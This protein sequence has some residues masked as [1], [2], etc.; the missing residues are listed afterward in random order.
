MKAAIL[1]AFAIVTAASAANAQALPPRAPHIVVLGSATVERPADW[2]SLSMTVR[3]EG[4]DQVEA[5]KTLSAS[6]DLIQSNISKL[7]GLAGVRFTADD[8]RITEIR[9]PDCRRQGDYSERESLTR[10]ACAIVGVVATIDL[11]I[12]FSPATKVGDVAAFAAQLGGKDVRIGSSGLTDDAG[13][14]AEALRRAFQA[15]ED[16]G[17]AIA[18]ATGGRLGVVL[19]V[20][21]SQAAVTTVGSEQLEVT[22]TLSVDTMLN[23]TPAIVPAVSL[24]LTPAPV[25]ATARITVDFALER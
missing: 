9:G 1:A 24:N 25:S 10:G 14:R 22:G 11:D 8:I 23:E 6:G 18:A 20:Q 16:E 21:D 7:P 12:R 15:A 3:G 19:L 17:R 4:L 5:Q 13:L 2:V